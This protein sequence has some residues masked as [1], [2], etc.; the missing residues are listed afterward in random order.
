MNMERISIETFCTHYHTEITFIEALED[1]G[2]I[3]VVE[4]DAVRYIDFEELERLERYIHLHH[5]LDVNV[6]GIE[7]IGVLLERI[8]AMQERLRILE[9]QHAVIGD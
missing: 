1:S 2:L 7:V 4:R 9:K 5:E 8:D 6:P 3:H